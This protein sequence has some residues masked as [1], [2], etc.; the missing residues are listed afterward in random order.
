MFDQGI[1]CSFWNRVSVHLSG[2]WDKR[3][4]RADHKIRK[5]AGKDANFL[6]HRPSRACIAIPPIAKPLWSLWA[7]A[8]EP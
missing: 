6:R 4:K 7:C 8:P 2:E 5:H 1:F 3:A